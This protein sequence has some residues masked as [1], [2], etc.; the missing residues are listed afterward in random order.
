MSAFHVDSEA[1]STAT[2]AVQASVGRIEGEVAALH[3]QLTGLQSSWSGNASAAFQ[4]AVTDWRSVEQ[5]VHESLAALNHALGFAGRQYAEV[6]A[7][8]ARLFV[9]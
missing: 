4:A 9:S 8:N 2:H 6:E 5:R 7:A 1:V 3:G